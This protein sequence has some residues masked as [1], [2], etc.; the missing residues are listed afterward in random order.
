MCLLET[1]SLQEEDIL[2]CWFSAVTMRT[3]QLILKSNMPIRFHNFVFTFISLS[4]SGRTQTCLTGRPIGENGVA[5]TFNVQEG[6]GKYN[7]YTS[8]KTAS[9]VFSTCNESI[10]VS[11]Q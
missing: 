8:S 9:A 6:R 11:L 1:H 4:L 10:G 3:G 2:C 5:K 7:L